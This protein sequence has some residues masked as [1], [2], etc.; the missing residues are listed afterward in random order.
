M[1]PHSGGRD[2]S[3]PDKVQVIAS[4]IWC[5]IGHMLPAAQGVAAAKCDLNIPGRTVSFE[6]DGSFQVTCQFIS[7]II[8]YKLD[9]TIF[10]SNNAGYTYE[11]LLHGLDAQ[12]KDV[13]EWRY[14]EAANFMGGRTDDT[15][16]AILVKEGDE[17]G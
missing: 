12:H 11:R 8:R 4:G 2:I 15:D 6:G 10:M 16:Y 5:S 1:A 9:V 14:T 3:L 13:P 17:L 7:D